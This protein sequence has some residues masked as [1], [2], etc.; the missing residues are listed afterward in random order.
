MKVLVVGGGGREHALVWKLKQS[1]RVKEVFCA[2][3]NAGIAREATC[4][5]TSAEDIPALLAFAR[6]KE[7][8]LTVVG[9]EAPLTAGI[10]DQ[11]QAAGLKIFGPTRAAAAIE[12]SKVIAKEIMAKYGIPTAACNIFTDPGEASAYIKKIG[13]PCVVKADGLAAGKGVIVAPDEQ[14]ALTAVREI[15]VDK[16]FGAAGNRLVVEECLVGEE[17]S[18]L[19]FTD[20]FNVVPMISSQD[21]KRVYDGD[22]GPN[23]GG[24]GAYAPAPV[25]TPEI[26]RETM[27]RILIPMVRA[28]SQEGRIYRGVLYAGL[29]VTSKGPQVLEFN[30][31]FGDPEAQPVLTLLESDLVEIIDAIL[32]NRL[33]RTEIRWK[34]QASICV[35]LASGGY[36]G[37]YE[38]GKTITGLEELPPGVVVFH[39]GTAEKNGDIVT[40]GGRVLG[41]TATGRDISGAFASAYKAVE[42][43]HFDGIHYRRDIGKRALD[44]RRQA[45]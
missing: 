14:T 16:V 30:A 37:S 19:A 8:D 41:V 15:M 45:E 40:A 31:R 33:D 26:H 13:A 22:Q 34:E 20:G 39:A 44:R 5:K 24:M 11:F 2:P 4:V 7:I 32:E 12:G 3:G 9:P 23:T 21:H 35:V 18:I 29:M 42:N 6:E 36:P 25:Y 1:P 17:V 10:V 27:D 43:I 28:L 38:K